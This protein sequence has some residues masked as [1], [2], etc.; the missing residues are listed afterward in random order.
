MNISYEEIGHVS[1]TFPAGTGTAGKVCKLD[2]SGKAAACS[3]GERFC[4]I[5]EHVGSAGA[6][7]QIHGFAVVSYTG[8][9]F[10]PGY[11]NLSANGSG[12]V[13]SDENGTS[14]LVARVDTAAKTAVIEL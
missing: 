1:V 3:V 2:S 7:V 8:T 11:V 10:V 13:K 5:V 12:G 9:A 6:A 14:Y 4:G